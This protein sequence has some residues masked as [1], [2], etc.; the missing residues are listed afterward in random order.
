MTM[1][2]AF[3]TVY[4]RAPYMPSD[5]EEEGICTRA[6]SDADVDAWN[7]AWNLAHARELSPALI[8]AVA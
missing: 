1:A 2:D 6:Q 8:L 5:W 4:G 3:E 7:A